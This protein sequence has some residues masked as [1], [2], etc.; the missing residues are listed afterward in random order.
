MKREVL[1]ICDANSRCLQMAKVIVN[2]RL[3]NEWDAVSVGIKAARQRL[4]L[5][6]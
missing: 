3:E 1:V 5:S 2:A 6:F 4:A